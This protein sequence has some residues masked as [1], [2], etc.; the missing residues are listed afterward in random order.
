MEAE[1][2]KEVLQQLLETD[3]GSTR[4]GEAAMVPMSSAVAAEGLIWNNTLYDENDGCHIAIGRA[5]PTCL[6]GGALMEP[7]ELAEAG[8]NISS[9]HVD[10]VVGSEQL[11]VYGVTGE[12]EDEPIIAAGEW[13]FEV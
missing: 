8:L 2:G 4:F 6:E 12:G 3:D 1:T 9:T 10:F 11:T 7:E 5:Y 13:A